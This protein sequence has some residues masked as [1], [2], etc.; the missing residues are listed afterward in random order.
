MKDG[1]G[2]IYE[3]LYEYGLRMISYLN[4]NEAGEMKQ[5]HSSYGE[6]DADYRNSNYP[7]TE[8]GY[9][10]LVSSTALTP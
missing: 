9:L 6:S 1:E 10:T 7:G 3:G 8:Y 5:V 4:P 2:E